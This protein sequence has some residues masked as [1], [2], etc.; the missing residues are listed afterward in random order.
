MNQLLGRL[1][2][3]VRPLSDDEWER[4]GLGEDVQ[5]P[6][7]AIELDNGL[8]VFH[9]ADGNGLDILTP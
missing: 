1:I 2:V 9:N 7:N 5:R 8:V 6:D 3:R 4:T